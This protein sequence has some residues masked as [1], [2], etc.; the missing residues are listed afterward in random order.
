MDQQTTAV[1]RFLEAVRTATIDECD[2]WAADAVL[3]ATVP[4]WRFHARGADA[5][6]AT[7]RT[8]FADQARFDELARYPVAGGEVVRYVLAWDEEAVPHAAHHVH[9][10][11]VAAD[12]IV[13]DVA[14]CGGRWPAALLAEMEAADAH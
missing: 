11:S 7:Y 12:R 2:A 6:R 13:A 5:I 8:W 3:D 14:M 9:V 4:H 1:T 10:L